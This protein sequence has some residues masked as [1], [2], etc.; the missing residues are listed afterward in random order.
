MTIIL[1]ECYHCAMFFRT[2]FH[3]KSFHW[4]FSHISSR[5]QSAASYRLLASRLSISSAVISICFITRLHKKKGRHIAKNSVIPTD[6]NL[7]PHLNSMTTE[8]KKRTFR[9]VQ[10]EMLR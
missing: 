5:N 7:Q 4:K 10:L 9:N 2:F 6:P 8:S 3:D 1:T